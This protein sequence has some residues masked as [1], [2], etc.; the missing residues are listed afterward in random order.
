MVAGRPF[1]M[2]MYSTLRVGVLARH[3]AQYKM[4][5]L[6]NAHTGNLPG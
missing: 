2:V 4:A 3:R 1:L 5:G 6:A